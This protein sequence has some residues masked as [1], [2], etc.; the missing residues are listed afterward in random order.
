MKS[1][2]NTIQ[3]GNSFDVKNVEIFD[4][5]QLLSAASVRIRNGWI[6]D[7][8]SI[9]LSSEN[10]APSI[11]GVGLFLM[12]SLIDFEGHFSTPNDMMLGLV[13]S[14]NIFVQNKLAELIKTESLFEVDTHG[15]NTGHGIRQSKLG[16]KG[17]IPLSS[18]F[19]K[20]IRFGV[21]TVI[22]QGAYPW[23]ANYVKRSRGRWQSD[24]PMD[25]RQEFLS[26]ADLYTSGM[27]AAP[28]GLHFS[29]FGTDPVYNS[30]SQ[31]QFQDWV[32]RRI[33]EDSDHI[34]IFYEKWGG[35][36]AAPQLSRDSLFKLTAA[37]HARGLKVIVHNG[38]GETTE[39]L[40]EA[41]VDGNIHTPFSYKDEVISDDLARRFVQNVRVVTPTLSVSLGDCTGK[42]SI[43]N[44]NVLN[45]FLN[46]DTK[47]YLNALDELRLQSSDYHSEDPDE[48]R[49]MFQTVAK[50][51]DAGA[52]LTLGSDS[53]SFGPYV[54]GLTLHHEMYLIFEAIRQFSK[55]D[56][57]IEALR[58]GTSSAARA[59]GLDVPSKKGDPR[60]FVKPGYR[61]DLL[62]LNASPRLDIRNTLKI[63]QV[64]KA[65]FQANRQ[66]VR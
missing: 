1:P 34:K 33:A 58:A 31:D 14:K 3:D 22:D 26:Y 21:T 61:A 5:E 12:P 55:R 19:E 59:Y 62:L 10:S 29:Y 52:L 9:P 37:A 25:L 45:Q 30:W 36:S 2:L 66:P 40:I 11:D 48:Y 63:R 23:P 28:A 64:F 47:P 50:L 17:P 56:P 41:K 54:E 20:H 51:C 35:A 32:D 27:W 6:T 65:G 46:S 57:A 44:P 39:D 7:V 8:S 15:L 24:D 16:T 13:S 53:G 49:F 43:S 60:G 18:N 42:Y 4:G 38:D